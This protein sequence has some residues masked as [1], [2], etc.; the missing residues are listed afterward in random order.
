MERK[1]KGKKVEMKEKKKEKREKLWNL[2]RKKGKC[3]INI[4]KIPKYPYNL[5]IDVNNLKRL[6]L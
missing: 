3:E 1:R 6:K 5:L 2:K 4:C